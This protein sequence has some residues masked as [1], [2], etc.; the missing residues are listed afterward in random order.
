[1]ATPG[2]LLAVRGTRYGLEVDDDGAAAVTVF[3]GTVE[4]LPRTAGFAPLAVRAGELCRFGPQAPPHAGPAPR[5][6]REESWRGGFVQRGAGPGDGH[7]Q[8]GEG[9]G[10]SRSEPQQRPQGHGQ[11]SGGGGSS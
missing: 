2:A 4:V 6:T 10:G 7:S 5:G 8:G 9:R 1:V 11:R 3:E